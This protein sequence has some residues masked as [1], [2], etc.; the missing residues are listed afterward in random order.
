MTTPFLHTPTNLTES[1]DCQVR[2]LITWQ[3]PEAVFSAALAVRAD[4][5]DKKDTA[6]KVIL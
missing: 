3:F 4:E 1:Q 6:R 2:E 5:Q